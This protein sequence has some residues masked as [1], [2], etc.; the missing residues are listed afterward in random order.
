MLILWVWGSYSENQ[1]RRVNSSYPLLWTKTL[2][3]KCLLWSGRKHNYGTWSCKDIVVGA[4]TAT[5]WQWIKNQENHWKPGWSPDIRG[6]WHSC[7]WNWQPLNT[8]S[9]RMDY[10][11]SSVAQSS[12][13]LWDP[14]DCSTLGFPV[15]HRLLEFV[16]THICRVGDAIQP[17]HPLSSPSPPTFNLSQHQG[18]FQWVSSSHR[19]AKVLEFQLQHQSVLLMNTQ[20]WFRLGL[21]GYSYY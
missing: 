7:I 13:T 3:H 5:M 8:L 4:V 18:L 11:F 19:M 12:P 1:W 9:C 15:H 2:N 17:S 21:T 16:Q 14:M 20:N 10:Q 6:S